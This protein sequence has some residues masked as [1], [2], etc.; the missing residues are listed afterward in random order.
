MTAKGWIDYFM[1][2]WT[3]NL[4]VNEF[5]F[6]FSR[7]CL[8]KLLPEALSPVPSPPGP[9]GPI[10]PVLD[11]TNRLSCNL[12]IPPVFILHVCTAD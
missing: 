9:Q 12:N 5:I 8:N 4:A 3:L 1:G 2:E 6:I 10:H 7:N 11:A